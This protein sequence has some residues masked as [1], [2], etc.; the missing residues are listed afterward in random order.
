MQNKNV[1]FEDI[2]GTKNYFYKKIPT[3]KTP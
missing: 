1:E 3:V 2:I